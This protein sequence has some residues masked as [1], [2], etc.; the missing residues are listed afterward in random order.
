MEPVDTSLSSLSSPPLSPTL[1]MLLMTS[2]AETSSS[3]SSSASSTSSITT[4]STVSVS[5]NNIFI[6]GETFNTGNGEEVA[7]EAL[8][9]AS[10][11]KDE[12]CN[13]CQ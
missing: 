7:I 1:P 10:D 11:G 5:E 13:H 3:S 6:S 4:T 2:N 12:N 9:N 8:E